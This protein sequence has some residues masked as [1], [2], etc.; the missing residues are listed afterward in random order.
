MMNMLEPE[1]FYCRM[2]K[3]QRESW[4]AAE[5]RFKFLFYMSLERNL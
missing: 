3:R 4:D 2:T 5:A 1:D